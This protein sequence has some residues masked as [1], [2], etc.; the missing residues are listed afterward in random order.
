MITV[1]P[2]LDKKAEFSHYAY[3]KN[4]ERI[5][6]DEAKELLLDS[7]ELC[8]SCPLGGDRKITAFSSGCEGSWCSEAFDNW[9]EENCE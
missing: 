2:C 1:K 3:F 8:D 9:C 5:T 4:G 6:E 7:E